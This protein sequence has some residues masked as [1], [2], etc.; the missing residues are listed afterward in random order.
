MLIEQGFDCECD[1]N[2]VKLFRKRKCLVELVCSG[3]GPVVFEPHPTVKTSPAIPANPLFFY[4]PQDS[5]GRI[6]LQGGW[7][8]KVLNLIGSDWI[9]DR[10]WREEKRP[11][12]R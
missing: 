7:R 5:L 2:D 9:G 10:D 11:E 4:V 3:V 1:F 6:E 12:R 8:A